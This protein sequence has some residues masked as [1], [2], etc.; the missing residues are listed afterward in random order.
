MQLDRIDLAILSEL[1]A[2]ARL[3]HVEVS[4]RVGLSTTACARRL[5]TLEDAGV[6]T[7]YRTALDLKRLGAGTTVIVRIA[8]ESQSEEALAAFEKAIATCPSVLR[9]FLMSGSDDYLVT[10]TVRDIEDFERVHKTQLSTLPQVARIQSSFALR[11]IVNRPVPPA[12]FDAG[13][14]GA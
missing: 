9:C 2:N 14:R 12:V 5:K 13:R 8:L 3:S 6:I 10:V 4:E 7:G 1:A 11:E